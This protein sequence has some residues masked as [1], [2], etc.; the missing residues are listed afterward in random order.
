VSSEH[1]DGY[2]ARAIYNSRYRT[3]NYQDAYYDTPIPR[4]VN[5]IVISALKAADNIIASG[6]NRKL[7]VL[8]FGCGDGRYRAAAY[9]IAKR[10]RTHGIDVEL[11]AYDVSDGG[12]DSFKAKLR[13][14]G[15]GVN[16]TRDNLSVSFVLGSVDSSDIE[17]NK[18][19]IG[20][21]DVSSAIFGVISHIP[22]RKN[23][24]NT[25]RMLK[26]VTDGD[27]II[28]APGWRI[29]SKEFQH[30]KK[31]RESGS[32][33]KL[34][35][36]PG[37]LYYKAKGGTENFYHVYWYKHELIG[38]LAEAGLKGKV[39][40]AKIGHETTLSYR[41]RTVGFV[42]E[43]VSYFAY[44]YLPEKASEYLAGYYLAKMHDKEKSVTH[45]VPGGL[46]Q[47]YINDICC[48]SQIRSHL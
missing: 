11:V 30:H 35:T 42:D 32:P 15:F 12:L 20:N 1:R 38:E 5:S 40:I 21:V 47:Q 18:I 28:T 8:D 48:L 24:V 27:V 19:A 10:V 23:R 22:G 46:A 4:N 29:L 44:N 45:V 14:E 31:L 41:P 33:Y 16:F 39:S 17:K 34:A 36:E 37:D 26:E 13:E 9:E 6:S 3:S 7:R 43:L 25:L 2:D